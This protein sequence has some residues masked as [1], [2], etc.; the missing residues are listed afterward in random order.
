[1]EKQYS[2][3]KVQS[4]KEQNNEM[5]EYHIHMQVVPEYYSTCTIFLWVD[6]S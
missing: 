3:V 2:K 1:M 5:N 6:N 4:K